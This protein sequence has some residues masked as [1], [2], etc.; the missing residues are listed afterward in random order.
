MVNRTHKTVVIR[1]SGFF[2]KLDPLEYSCFKPIKLPAAVKKNAH[3][4]MISKVNI[5]SA[6]IPSVS[7]T[8]PLLITSKRNRPNAR[9]G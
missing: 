9:A 2:L 5:G 1:Y 4:L 7:V 6:V 3:S 8:R